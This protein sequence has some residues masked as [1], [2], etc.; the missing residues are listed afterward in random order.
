MLKKVIFGVF[1]G[2][3]VVVLALGFVFFNLKSNS[4]YYAQRTP[5]KA[6][7]EPV[8]MELVRNLRWVSNPDIKGIKYDF[9]GNNIIHNIDSAGRDNAFTYYP[10]GVYKYYYDSGALAYY[11]D[12]HFKF[13]GTFNGKTLKYSTK[14]VNLSAVKR[15]IYRVVQPVIDAQPEPLINLQWI[16]DWVNKDRFN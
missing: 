2:F 3:I 13:I 10:R 5:H 14:P 4:V 16:Y 15:D 9:D 8:V 11:F 6:G 1:I 7:M 12:K